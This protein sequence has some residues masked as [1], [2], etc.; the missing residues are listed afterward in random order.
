M[1]TIQAQ[2]LGPAGGEAGPLQR[3]RQLREGEGPIEISG[4]RQSACLN[5][6]LDG[7]LGGRREGVG[8]G[9]GAWANSEAFIHEAMIF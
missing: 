5:G 8:A 9:V 3:A 1:R 2:P 7:F 4:R 6:R